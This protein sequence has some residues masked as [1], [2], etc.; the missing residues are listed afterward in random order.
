MTHNLGHTKF[1]QAWAQAGWAKFITRATR[2]STAKT[3]QDIWVQPLDET[4]QPFPFVPTEAYEGG[5]QLSPDGRWLA[6]AS[7]ESD[8]F[9]VYAQHF[10]DGSAGWE[11]RG[12][13]AGH[14]RGAL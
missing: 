6:Y 13:R 10:P 3:R 7:D 1:F 5:A 12:L 4:Q 2:G 9:E 8:M 11:R 14:R